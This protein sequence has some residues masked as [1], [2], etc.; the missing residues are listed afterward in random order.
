MENKKNS[1]VMHTEFATIGMI[2]SVPDR[3][4]LTG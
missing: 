4:R 3:D 2:L 1:E